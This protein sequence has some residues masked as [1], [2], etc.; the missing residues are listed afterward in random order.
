MKAFIKLIILKLLFL[1]ILPL[2][3][4]K[5]FLSYISSHLYM[6]INVTHIDSLHYEIFMFWTNCT[7]IYGGM[8]TFVYNKKNFICN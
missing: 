2:H 7:I 1:A 6:I 3:I 5:S 8:Y 4:F